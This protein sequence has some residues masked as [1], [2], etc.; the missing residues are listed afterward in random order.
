MRDVESV[1]F[2]E[3]GEMERAEGLKELELE[4]HSVLAG[5]PPR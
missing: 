1:E 4:D 2:H 3:E 5:L